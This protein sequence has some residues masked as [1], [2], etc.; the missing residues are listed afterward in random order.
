[1][2]SRH[3]IAPAT[4]PSARL[5]RARSRPT[6]GPGAPPTAD[7]LAGPIPSRILKEVGLFTALTAAYF[8]AGKIG[9]RLATVHVSATTVGPPAV[10]PRAA[11][12]FLG[13]L[14]WAARF[15]G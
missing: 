1:M 13:L 15:V 12:P 6:P 3:P 11:Y 2:S 4:E 10:I 8:V 14:T 5:R 7:H 9:L